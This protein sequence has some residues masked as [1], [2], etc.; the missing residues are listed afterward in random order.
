MPWMESSSLSPTCAD[1]TR[2]CQC[3]KNN[4]QKKLNK[5]ARCMM[6]VVMVQCY[7]QYINQQWPGVSARATPS[8]WILPFRGASPQSSRGSY[9][10]PGAQRGHEIPDTGSGT[11]PG[12]RQHWHLFQLESSKNRMRP[13]TP[14]YA[15]SFMRPASHHN[16]Q[17]RTWGR[18]FTTTVTLRSTWYSVTILPGR[19]NPWL[20]IMRNLKRIP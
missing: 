2:D 12:Q 13:V 5:H 6:A 14:Q 19:P 4:P 10:S 17:Q 16:A 8:C 7:Q 3:L 1:A 15:I 20:T 9:V 11:Q 18:Q